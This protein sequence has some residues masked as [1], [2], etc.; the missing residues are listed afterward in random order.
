MKLKQIQQKRSF[1]KK[2]LY[3]ANSILVDKHLTRRERIYI[4]LLKWSAKQLISIH[5]ECSI[6][7]GLN[8]PE[9]YTCSYCNR[10]VSIGRKCNCGFKNI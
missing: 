6:D 8:V 7:M 5:D 10:E 4:C 2:Q 1:L 9:K 3:F